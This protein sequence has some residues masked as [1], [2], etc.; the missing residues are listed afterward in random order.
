[1]L[2]TS[3][4]PIG[5]WYFSVAAQSKMRKSSSPMIPLIARVAKILLQSRKCNSASY[6]DWVIATPPTET[7]VYCRIRDSQWQGRRVIGKLSFTK[8]PHKTKACGRYE[9]H[10]PLLTDAL[11]R[12][13]YQAAS[14]YCTWKLLETTWK[15]FVS[16]WMASAIESLSLLSSLSRCNQNWTHTIMHHAFKAWCIVSTSG[17]YAIKTPDFDKKSGVFLTFLRKNRS[18]FQFELTP[19]WP[20]LGFEKF[21]KYR[22]SRVNPNLKHPLYA[23]VDSKMPIWSDRGGVWIKTCLKIRHKMYNKNPCYSRLLRF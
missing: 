20:Q 5:A 6:S 11:C 1:M 13:D 12:W 2:F 3:S 7:T 19:F 18:A 14:Q 23:L 22:K 9:K 8:F 16:F 15:C 4:L 21:G 17:R 10:L